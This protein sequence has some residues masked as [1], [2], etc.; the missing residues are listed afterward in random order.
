MIDDPEEKAMTSYDAVVATIKKLATT[1]FKN[2][3]AI[4]NHMKGLI[5]AMEKL[6][7]DYA[8]VGH[9]KLG[10]GVLAIRNKMLTLSRRIAAGKETSV[11]AIKEAGEAALKDMTSLS[12]KTADKYHEK[13]GIRNLSKA[14]EGFNKKRVKLSTDSATA[15]F[16]LEKVPFLLLFKTKINP[17]VKKLLQSFNATFYQGTNGV[18]VPGVPVLVLNRK[19]VAEKDYD[20]QIKAILK[21][22]KRPD[23]AVFKEEGVVRGDFIA[24]PV[25]EP[26]DAEIMSVVFFSQLQNRELWVE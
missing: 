10:A 3:A 16:K 23:L 14:F 22:L 6:A 19:V 15:S 12:P 25:F 11:S 9:N 13:A 24:F 4:L 17:Q 1:T 18:S 7:E 26:R 2:R 20:R 8:S 21:G 5:P